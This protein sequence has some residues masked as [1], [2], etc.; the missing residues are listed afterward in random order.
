LRPWVYERHVWQCLRGILHINPDQEARARKT[1]LE[2]DST[3]HA[4][5]YAEEGQDWEDAYRQ[6]QTERAA[7]IRQDVELAALRRTL[8]D[9]AGLSPGESLPAGPGTALLSTI[10]QTVEETADA[11]Q[12]AA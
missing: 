9:Q 1:D 12:Q 4:A 7:K 2:T 10:E 8:E 3:T 5:I 11:P 6:R